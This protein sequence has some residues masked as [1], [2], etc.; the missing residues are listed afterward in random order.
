MLGPKSTRDE[1]GYQQPGQPEKARDRPVIPAGQHRGTRQ[2]NLAYGNLA[3]DPAENANNGSGHSG[4]ELVEQSG[5][6][7]LGDG[8]TPAD[9]QTADDV[10]HR[11][12]RE[13]GVQALAKRCRKDDGEPDRSEDHR[14]RPTAKQQ[15]PAVPGVGEH[16]VKAQLPRC[17]TYPMA[18]PA[19][20]PATTATTIGDP[21][22]GDLAGQFQ[23]PIKRGQAAR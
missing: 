2:P 8:H 18:V 13:S 14:Q 4:A 7:A 10:G 17:R 5:D 9:Q 11:P 21:S 1:N 19:S 20:S 15:E 16:R 3:T 6:T 22:C 23:H 12:E